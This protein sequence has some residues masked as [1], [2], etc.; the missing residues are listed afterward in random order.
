MSVRVFLSI[1]V[2]VTDQSTV[3]QNMIVVLVIVRIV[4]S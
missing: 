3:S 4:N 2:Y 1:H